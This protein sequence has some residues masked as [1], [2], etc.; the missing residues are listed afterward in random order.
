MADPAHLRRV[1]GEGTPVDAEDGVRE[2]SRQPQ[3]P[4][5]VPVRVP[6]GEPHAERL[7][8]RRS[9][10]EEERDHVRQH[11]VGPR[12]PPKLRCQ[13]PREAD[14]SAEPRARAELAH[15]HVRGQPAVRTDR[16][17]EDDELVRARC[18]R[19]DEVERLRE[20][21]VLGVERLGDEDEPH[22]AI[23]RSTSSRYA[24]ANSAGV[25][26]QSA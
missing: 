10:D 4:S 22:Q 16:R 6:E 20:R 2:S 19:V 11:G 8:E 17:A 12:G 23:V 15:A 21:G 5:R 18:E 9:E 3:R 14:A 24:A 13:R 26:C 7:R 25:E 1:E